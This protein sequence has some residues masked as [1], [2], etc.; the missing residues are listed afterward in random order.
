MQ[1]TLIAKREPYR[2]ADEVLAVMASRWK[3]S[4]ER[5]GAADWVEF[6]IIGW[7]C[8]SRNPVR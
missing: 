3:S 6:P 1:T 5:T 2:L 4:C 7:E 8:I